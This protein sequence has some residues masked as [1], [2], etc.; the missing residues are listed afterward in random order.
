VATI[1]AGAIVIA[2]VAGIGILLLSLGRNAYR[3]A[4]S[5]DRLV[6]G[7]VEVQGNRVLDTQEIVQLAGIRKGS[8]IL[9][10]DLLQ[11][12]RR[13]ARHPRVESVVVERHL[14]RT[15]IVT[16]KERLP[17][18]LVQE[19][20]VIKGIDATGTIV[21]IDP[22][23]E[24]IKGPIITGRLDANAM[25]LRLEAIAALEAMRPDLVN[26]ISEITIDNEG[27]L[28]LIVSGTKTVIR[29]GSG[30]IESKIAKLRR[31]LK[32]FDER[33]EVKTYIDLR[34]ADIYTKP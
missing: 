5:T 30:D 18:A 15:V 21:P 17:I 14:P 12:K 16:V 19:S 28:T 31:A 13:I 24:S 29:L 9:G 33:G 10:L 4:V 27:G 11:I 22:A 1:I 26:R 20:G 25:E 32:A 2:V 23:R 34:Y 7:E 3:Y 6:V 8:S